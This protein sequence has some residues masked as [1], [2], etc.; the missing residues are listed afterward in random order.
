MN[1]FQ[2]YVRAHWALCIIARGKKGPEY[3]RW[4]ERPIDVETA[5]GIDGAGLLHVQ[6][7]T[8]AL[9]IDNLEAARPWLLERNVDLDALLNAKDSVQISSGRPNRAKLLFRLRTSLRTLKPPGSGIELR[10]ATAQNKSVQD[11]LPPSIHPE[12]KKPYFWVF[13]EPLLGDWSRLPSIP[14]TLLSVWRE[15]LA[16]TPAPRGN[17]HS[18]EPLDIPLE[19]LHA[20]IATQD[21]NAPYD[22]WIKV[23]MRLHD[24]TDGAE[25]GL[26]VWEGWS[27]KA[28]RQG[29]K[30]CVYVKG[31]TRAHWLSFSSPKG[32]VLATLNAELPAQAEEF[33]LVPGEV[34]RVIPPDSASGITRDTA[35]AGAWTH[36]AQ[37]L[38]ARLVY[39]RT[40]ERYFDTR[41]HQLIGSDSAIEHQFTAMLP[42]VK[43]APLNPVKVLKR[44]T[45]KRTVEGLAFHPGE[46]AL[47]NFD[48][49]TF[50]NSYRNRLPTPVEPTPLELEKIE[51]FFAR[52]D[53]EIYRQWLKQYLGHVVQKPGV[54]IRS[55]PLIWSETQRSG[56]STLLKT[57]PALIVGREFSKDVDY[58][59]LNS[60]F[61]D[62]LQRAW[63]VNLTEFRA[64]TRG[65]RTMI[66]NKLKAYIADDTVP[67][68]PKGH[69]GY[70]MPN[71]FF[72]TATSNEDDAAAIDNNDERWGIH[73]LK[74]PPFTEEERQWF[75]F[76]FMRLPRAAAVL[77]WY[78]L[79]IDL[80]GF[81]AD[82]SAPMTEAKQ[83]M[84]DASITA[85]M[86]L[87][88]WMYE[89]QAQFF[90]KDVVVV[91]EVQAYVHQ[92]SV[93]KSSLIR[94]GK[95]L[96]KEP[97]KGKPIRFRVKGKLYR[98]VVI[99]NHNKWFTASG[100]D[101][102]SHIQG[103]D[104]IDLL[105]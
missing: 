59:L 32:K 7:G 19:R 18:Q 16:D 58:A 6:S 66:N 9:D 91:N 95:V 13:G 10:C 75:Q 28:T 45:T 8:C 17:G 39:V 47:F 22:D 69:T 30:G 94:I 57:I 54:K 93:A 98:G 44:S 14:A 27:A 12:T 5:A 50:A 1:P 63:H 25:E 76:Q 73:E 64:G 90:A 3:S 92:H 89:E 55:A 49:D 80:N 67:L 87:L 85:D 65:E 53:D 103:E 11:V 51:W 70:T 31:A 38:E 84:V 35:K 46:G 100:E 34:S 96:A 68:Q 82:G 56:K 83:A 36:A 102:I 86:E 105:S 48:G 15:L 62:Y 37:I 26:T 101:I 52:I 77:R 24:A 79:H 61:N 43:G 42:R 33:E 23:G 29:P 4:N 72:V 97:F 2:E 60:D 21:P 88:K 20:W 104:S 78:F 40:S 71:H 74:A 99:R 41:Y 81:H